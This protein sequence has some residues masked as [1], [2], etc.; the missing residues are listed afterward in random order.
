MNWIKEKVLGIIINKYVAGWIGGL[1]GKIKGYKTQ[2]GA[3][4]IVAIIVAKHLGWIPT[5]FLPV[6]DQVLNIIYGA[7]GI[8]AGDKLRRIW[9]QAKE[10]GDEAIAK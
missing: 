7:T 2:V 3:V 6:A 8:S 10:I 9:S 1:F 4:L 5:E